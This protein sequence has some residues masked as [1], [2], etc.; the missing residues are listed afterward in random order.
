MLFPSLNSWTGW[1]FFSPRRLSF[2]K[3]FG[4]WGIFPFPRVST[5]SITILIEQ[6]IYSLG[7]GNFLFV[8]FPWRSNRFVL[9]LDRY[10]AMGRRKPRTAIYQVFLSRGEA[11][12]SGRGRVWGAM[13]VV[14]VRT[15]WWP[16]GCSFRNEQ[17]RRW[18]IYSSPKQFGLES[19]SFLGER[20]TGRKRRFLSYRRVLGRWRLLRVGT[21]Y[22]R[23]LLLNPNPCVLL[24]YCF[25]WALLQAWERS[26]SSR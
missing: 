26:S 23:M 6:W 19:G 22:L 24:D 1:A 12:L 9:D 8:N 4:G 2:L 25:S 18:I 21:S 11:V 13:E 15:I 7:N 20:W 10:Q 5:L 16:L 3:Y 17:V 14:W